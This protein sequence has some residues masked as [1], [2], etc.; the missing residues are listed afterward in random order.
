MIHGRFIGNVKTPSFLIL[1]DKMSQ[2]PKKLVKSPLVMIKARNHPRPVPSFVSAYL[3]TFTTVIKNIR[4]KN[5]RSNWEIALI[6]QMMDKRNEAKS[7]F[8]EVSQYKSQG[9]LDG[10]K[11]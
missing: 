11:K 5:I 2:S 6:Q 10:A 4:I 7:C 1:K 9:Y 3:F 8:Q